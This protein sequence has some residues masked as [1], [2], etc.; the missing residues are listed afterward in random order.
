MILLFSGGQDSTLLALRYAYQIRILLHVRYDHPAAQQE[1]RACRDIYNY[2]RENRSEAVEYVALSVPISAAAM[3][4]GPRIEGPRY[5]PCR[6]A[7]MLSIAANIAHTR[8]IHTIMYGANRDD[9]ADYDDCRGDYMDVLSELL[10]IRIYAPL[11]ETSKREIVEDLSGYS[12][13]VT[14]LVWS[15]YEPIGGARCGA[16]N[17]CTLAAP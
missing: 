7:V 6:N 2:I 15:C 9:Y 16:C 5:V 1:G 10:G 4:I 11:L 17:S 14:D 3:R 12:N 13:G 8:G